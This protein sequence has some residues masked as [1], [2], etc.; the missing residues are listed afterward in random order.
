MID[1][2]AAE[3]PDSTD[4]E[5]SEIFRRRHHSDTPELTP[6]LKAAYAHAGTVWR[7]TSAIDGWEVESA[8]PP[9][10]D[11]PCLVTR[12]ENDFVTDDLIEDWNKVFTKTEKYVHPGCGH[13]ALNEKPDEYVQNLEKWLARWD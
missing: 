11:L 1:K 10:K 4:G 6:N 7:G 2:I 8:L 12:G 9:V 5:R 3:Y 13:H